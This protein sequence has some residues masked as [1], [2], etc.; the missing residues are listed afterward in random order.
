LTN[1]SRHDTSL[2]PVIIRI[3]QDQ[4]PQTVR[5]LVTL[6]K[7]HTSTPEPEI[8]DQILRLQTEGKI[9]LTE[10]SKPVPQALSTFA[11]TAHWYWLTLIL[12]T[13]TTIIVY[14]IPEDAYPLIYIRHLLGIVFVIWLPG[15]SLIKALFPTEPPIKTS[16]KNLDSIERIALSV[17]MSLALVPITGLILNYTPYGIRLTPIVLSLLILTITF[18][19]AGIIREHKSQLMKKT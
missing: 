17:G 1:N 10:P 11:K 12:A 2:T 8:L 14:T 9:T 7:K 6:V 18:A 16:S 13:A 15:Y 3:V 5:Q 19:T 4:K